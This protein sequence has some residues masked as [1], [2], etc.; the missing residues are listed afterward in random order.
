MIAHSIAN[1]ACIHAQF[2]LPRQPF[3]K[4]PW[5]CQIKPAVLIISAKASDGMTGVSPFFRNV[6][7]HAK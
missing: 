5:G 6:T 4:L 3:L 7:Y 2:S 1:P